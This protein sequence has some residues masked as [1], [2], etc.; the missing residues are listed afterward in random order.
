MSQYSTPGHRE[1]RRVLNP[2]RSC[3]SHSSRVPGTTE[4][5]AVL[6][7]EV[8]HVSDRKTAAGISWKLERTGVMSSESSNPLRS[9]LDPASYETLRQQVL[10]RDGWRCQFCG[11]LASLEIHHKQFRSH[12]GDDSEQNLITPCRP[13]HAKAHKPRNETGRAGARRK[14]H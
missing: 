1:R 6:D 10:R 12:S 13:C 14:D 9:R 3:A 11:A 5:S 4:D 8:L 2:C 7:D